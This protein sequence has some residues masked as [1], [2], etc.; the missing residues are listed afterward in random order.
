MKPKEDNQD[1]IVEIFSGTPWE[2]GMIKSMLEDS[3][4][5]CFIK[6]DILNDYAIEPTFQAGV[7]AMI[8]GSDFDKAKEIVEGYYRNLGSDPH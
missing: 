3:E 7:K 8:S 1:P 6:N 2:A 5:P 4:I